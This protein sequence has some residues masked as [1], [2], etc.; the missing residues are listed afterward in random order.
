VQVAPDGSS[1]Y[2]TVKTVGGQINPD[3]FAQTYSFAAT[4][5]RRIRVAVTGLGS[6]ASDEAS[7]RRLQLSEMQV[8]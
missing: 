7:V 1:T 5:A 8:Y 2:T 6:P 3:Q 4:S